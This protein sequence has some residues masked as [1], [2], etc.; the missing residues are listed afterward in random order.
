MYI[1]L[2]LF[3]LASGG[4]GT[5]APAG[6]LP[7]EFT[8][9]FR[10]QIPAS[11]GPFGKSVNARVERVQKC[12]E[13][14]TLT[15]GIFCS[16]LKDAGKC[17]GGIAR[18]EEHAREENLRRVSSSPRISA[19]GVADETEAPATRCAAALGRTPRPPPPLQCWY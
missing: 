5:H 8:G 19:V 13:N 12:I 3:S 9:N 14:D 18:Q 16:G 11:I 7:L 6:A 2:T 10:P 17:A 1:C 15:R 4:R